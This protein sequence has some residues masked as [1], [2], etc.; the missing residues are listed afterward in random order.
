MGI[1][2]NCNGK[3]FVSSYSYWGTIRSTILRA[4]LDCL[5]EKMKEKEQDKKDVK[6]EKIEKEEDKK[7]VEEEEEE[8]YDL[9]RY[10]GIL[11][12]LIDAIDR[13]KPSM[14]CGAEIDNYIPTFLKECEKYHVLNMLNFFEVGGLYALCNQCDC[15]GNY[16]S[17]N[18]M[19]I[20]I[21]LDKIEPFVKQKN[22]DC[23]ECIYVSEGRFYNRL[24]DVFDESYKTRKLVEIF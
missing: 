2:L 7:D 13:T 5:I 20:C 24:Y 8:D 22:V 12:D 14:F 9:K 17:G 16:T 18:S 6:I 15:E 1:Q 11:K 21:L 4:T 10:S 23:Y 19:D 3:S